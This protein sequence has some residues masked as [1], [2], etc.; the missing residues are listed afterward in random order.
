MREAGPTP[1]VS[2]RQIPLIRIQ[3]IISHNSPRNFRL[4]EW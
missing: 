1:T 2:F 3:L 4:R